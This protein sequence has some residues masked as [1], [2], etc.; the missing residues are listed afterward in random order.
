MHQ[1]Q[2]WTASGYY[3]SQQTVDE[4]WCHVG[5]V[6]GIIGHTVIRHLELARDIIYNRKREES[7]LTIQSFFRFVHNRTQ[8]LSNILL[9]EDASLDTIL[10]TDKNA[11][12]E[13]DNKWNMFVFGYFRQNKIY[14]PTTIINYVLLFAYYKSYLVQR[15]AL[16]KAKQHW[17][18]FGRVSS[19]LGASVCRHLE[20]AR[21]HIST[22]K[23]HDAALYMQIMFRQNLARKEINIKLKQQKAGTNLRLSITAQSND[24]SMKIDEIEDELQNVSSNHIYNKL[25]EILIEI[26]EVK[27]NQNIILQQLTKF[28]QN[29]M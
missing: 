11:I 20:I 9:D 22:R 18:Y 16:K 19:L 4:A 17:A 7:A 28:N 23:E 24:I 29:Q 27:A 6:S 26:Q 25:Q 13:I 2:H 10:K 1:K 12:I 14:F 8:F 5:R 15:V 3:K 21:H